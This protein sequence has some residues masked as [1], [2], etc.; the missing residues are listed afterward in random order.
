MWIYRILLSRESRQLAVD[1]VLE[2]GS[3][4]RG[5][6][7]YD[8]CEVWR[9]RELRRNEAVV[10]RARLVKSVTGRL[11][12]VTSYPSPPEHNRTIASADTSK[13]QF[14]LNT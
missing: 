2:W 3:R 9:Y 6:E 13:T 14:S 11:T 4:G 1:G 8:G 10:Q 5:G 12:G 7:W